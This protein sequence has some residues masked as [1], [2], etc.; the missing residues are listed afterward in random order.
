MDSHHGAIGGRE[1][2][3]QPLVSLCSCLLYDPR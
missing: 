1:A 2:D 3:E